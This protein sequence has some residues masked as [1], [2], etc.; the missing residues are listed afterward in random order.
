MVSQDSVRIE[1][2]YAALNNLDILSCNISNAYLESARGEKLWTMIEKE[3][4]IMDGTPMQINQELYE[5]K[6]AGNSC[7]KYLNKNLSV[8]NAYGV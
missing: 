2:L 3:F 4:G 1:F 8:M 7:N 6:S 5:I